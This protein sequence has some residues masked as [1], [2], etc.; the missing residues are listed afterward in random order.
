[1]GII[2]KIYDKGEDTINQLKMKYQNPLREF[3]KEIQNLKA[4][5]K[6]SKSLAAHINALKI[7]AEKDI[8][9][10]SELVLK[11]HKKAEDTILNGQSDVSAAETITLNALKLK[12][13]Y[14]NRI[15]ELQIKIPLYNEEL[16]FL[17]EKISDLILKIEYY[18]KEYE[19]LKKKTTIQSNFELKLF[20]NDTSVISRL[21]K[22]KDSILNQKKDFYEKESD[23]LYTNVKTDDIFDEYN[24]LKEKLKK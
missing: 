24:T 18:E 4:C 14:Q 13:T 12:K 9:S 16:E 15:D 1:M 22:L 11:Y 10:H 20:Y 17:K 3:E 7:R 6:E 5:L 19:F 23:N 2:R 8:V 21:E